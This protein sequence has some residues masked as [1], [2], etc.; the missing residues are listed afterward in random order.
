VRTQLSL[1]L[2]GIVCQA[3]LPKI[4][5]GR[6]AALEIMVPN[7][8]I[9]N[10]IREDRFIR[11]TRPCRPGQEKLGMQT[12]NQ[13][14]ATLYQRKQ[15]TL[16]LA[17]GASSNRDR[18]AGLDQSRRRAWSAGAGLGRPGRSSA[19]APGGEVNG[20]L[21]IQRRTRAG[22]TITGERA[23]TP[24]DAAVAALRREQ[25]L[26]T[27]IN[28]DEGEGCRQGEGARRDKA[29]AAKN[30]AIFTRQFSVMI[31]AAYRWCNALRSSAIRRKTRIFR[32]SSW[33]H[34]AT[35]RAARRWAD[36]MRK[37][38]KT[39]TRSSPT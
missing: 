2:E 17:L 15:I 26:V 3:L 11:S 30:L 10:L 7:A 8:A 4:G 5:G 39:S 24:L 20:I 29:V 14:L 9:R 37:H 28:A 38:P 36:A 16:E 35:S 31:D 19:A 12:M 1:V 23:Q 21:R 33:R 32:R 22:Q 13:S 18:I 34:E 27:Q 25:I 6:V